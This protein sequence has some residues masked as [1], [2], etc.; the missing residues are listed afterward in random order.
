MVAT[1]AVGTRIERGLR[2]LLAEV[3]ELPAVA[4][5]WNAWSELERVDFSLEWDHLMADTLTELDE[6]ARGP[7]MTP[8]QHAR[9][10]QLRHAL[11]H[12]LPL[13]DR[14]GLYRPTLALDRQQ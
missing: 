13:I 11:E 4:A 8:E 12:A 10:D 2:A 6:G 14:L 1:A 7:L 3:A 5:A 9:Y